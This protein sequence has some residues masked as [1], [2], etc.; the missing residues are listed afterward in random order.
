MTPKF[1]INAPE[2]AATSGPV[3]SIVMGGF[4]VAWTA[5]Q[6]VWVQSFTP[7]G[8]V[9]SDLI[10]AN[11]TAADKDHPPAICRLAD[12]TVVVSWGDAEA[13][14]GVSAQRFGSDLTKLGAEFPVNTSQGLHAMPAIAALD[15]AGFVIGWQGGTPSMMG[16]FRIFNPDG[17][18]SVAEQLARHDL[19]PAPDTLAPVPQGQFA[20]VHLQSEV[21]TGPDRENIFAV[22]LYGS[23]GSFVGDGPVTPQGS[24]TIST[25]PVIK[26]LPVSGLV[27]AWTERMVPSTGIFGQQIKTMLLGDDL[28]PGVS[29]TVNTS[30]R[31]G[32]DM[33][34]VTPVMTDSGGSVLAYSWVDIPLT[35]QPGQPTLKMRILPES[36]AGD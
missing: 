13:F 2:Q 27:V 33:P 34:C 10:K 25:H 12:A 11:T 22:S 18:Q 15:D 30:P 5:G 7:D 24:Q 14:V 28:T 3:I 1:T 35:G 8:A 26:A 31:A 6:D 23:D 9:M 16:R 19:Y 20:G 32:Q 17:S 29:A 21:F 36:L 4:A